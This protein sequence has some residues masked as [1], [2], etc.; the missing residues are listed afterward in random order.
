MNGEIRTVDLFDDDGILKLSS[1]S[2]SI[3]EV[4]SVDYRTGRVQLNDI[5]NTQPFTLR[6]AA[7]NNTVV[8]RGQLLLS[9][10]PGDI[11]VNT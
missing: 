6:V 3:K 1:G 9:T 10:V 7:E 2:S 5:Q 4:G 11:E 8:G